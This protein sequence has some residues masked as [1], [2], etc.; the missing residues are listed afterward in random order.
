MSHDTGGSVLRPESHAVSVEELRALALW[1]RLGV[2][3]LERVAR[4]ARRQ[5]VPGGVVL[6]REG[7]PADTVYLIIEGRVSLSLR[8][9]G[10]DDAIVGTLAAGELL[11][12][13]ALLPDQAPGSAPERAWTATART[14]A[15]GSLLVIPRQELVAA[16]ELNHEIGYYVMRNAL[17]A[18]ASRLRDTRIQLLDMFG[19]P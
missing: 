15:P 9:P 1:S 13:S 7:E 4:M 3:H 8:V 14:L 18:V 16:C 11:G 17:S 2:D 10:R 12:W 5:E 19:N 6:F